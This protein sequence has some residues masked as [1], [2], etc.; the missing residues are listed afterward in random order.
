[1]NKTI[2]A[3]SILFKDLP[4]HHLDAVLK[5]A[6][7]KTLEK[8][9]HIFSE[10]DPGSGFYIVVEGQIKIYKL[11]MEGKE[12]ILH[13]FGP[14]E[15]FGEVPVFSGDVF[16][17]S[18]EAV[19]RC[20]VLFFP[21][22]RFIALINEDPTLALNMLAVL[23]KRLRQFTV[24]IENLSLKEVPGRLAGYL[25]LLS[26]EQQSQSNVTLHI[27]K[28]HLASFLGTIPE[29][30]SRILKKMSEQGLIQV[31]GREIKI[32]DFEGLEILAE[33]GRLD[34]NGI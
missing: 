18:A 5:I 32:L 27:S 30:L 21:R 6:V 7:K 11:S 26:E 13:I 22:E 14:G 28:G 29:T 10:G 2:A 34:E 31:N 25:L 3:Q 24:Q 33:S 17:A 15:P 16:P 4:A 12:H 8:G 23:S 9:E 20:R 19:K 1:M